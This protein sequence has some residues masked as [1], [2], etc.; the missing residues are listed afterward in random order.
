MSIAKITLHVH[1]RTWAEKQQAG[2]AA[3]ASPH[4]TDVDNHIE[5]R[6]F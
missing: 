1:V 6:A 5:V 3:W 4:V 2:L